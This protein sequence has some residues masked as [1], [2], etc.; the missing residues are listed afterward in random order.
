MA[1]WLQHMMFTGTLL[2]T[3]P[4]KFR[5]LKQDGNVNI[6]FLRRVGAEYIRLGYVKLHNI[7]YKRSDEKYYLGMLKYDI[8]MKKTIER[9]KKNKVL[10]EEEY[11]GI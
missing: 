7:I 8:D 5:Y 9:L 4:V 1:Y 3:T 6:N 10:K 2:K 11:N